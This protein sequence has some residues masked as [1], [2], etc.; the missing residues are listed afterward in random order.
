[1]NT[2]DA[3]SVQRT[4][5]PSLN[6]RCTDVSTWLSGLVQAVSDR[7]SSHSSA[8]RVTKKSDSTVSIVSSRPELRA[9]RPFSTRARRRRLGCHRKWLGVRRSSIKNT[10]A[11]RADRTGD[12][13]HSSQRFRWSFMGHRQRHSKPQQYDVAAPLSTNILSRTLSLDSQSTVD[14][15]ECSIDGHSRAISF[16][17]TLDDSSSKDDEDC[18]SKEI[19]KSFGSIGAEIDRRWFE[20]AQAPLADARAGAFN[21]SVHSAIKNE[22]I[23]KR[24][25]SAPSR[26][27]T[28]IAGARH[29]F[30]DFLVEEQEWQNAERRLAEDL[31]PY[32]EKEAVEEEE[33]ARQSEERRRVADDRHHYLIKEAVEEEEQERQNEER[34]T[35]R[36]K[37]G[38]KWRR[39]L[40]DFIRP[41]PPRSRRPSLAPSETEY[42][43]SINF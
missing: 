34:P 23:L 39:K 25:Q 2:P 8:D 14:Y 10:Y 11:G 13:T 21:V 15:S 24:R 30:A 1:M 41:K 31:R 40:E 32:L 42:D 28:R 26:A 20:E 7:L 38:R 19:D 18:F 35:G 6:S 9:F 36:V 4:S 43:I 3:F 37:R 17:K 33:Q 22:R 29:F 5:P 16:S 27:K 12:S